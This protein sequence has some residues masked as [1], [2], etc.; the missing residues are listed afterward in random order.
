MTD[1]KIL[2]QS[3]PDAGVDQSIYQVPPGKSVIIRSINI[4]NTSQVSDEYDIAYTDGLVVPPVTPQPQDYI[5]FNN[6]ILAEE[7]IT[8]KSGYTLSE[9]NSIVVKS[10]AGN[11][12]FQVF[13]AEI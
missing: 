8:N 3:A 12:T 1:Y 5:N 7:T 6:T 11:T 9:N 4:T 13:G 10:S 2:A